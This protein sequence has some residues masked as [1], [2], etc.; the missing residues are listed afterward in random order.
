M[1]L[2]GNPHSC[3]I[4][5]VNLVSCLLP[6]HTC[7]P[8]Y[9][10]LCLHFSRPLLSYEPCI[11]LHYITI[12]LIFKK[13]RK[14]DPGN[15]QA[16]SLISV[17]GKIMEQILLEDMLRCMEDRELIQDSQHGFTKG[18]TCL[19]NLVTFYGVTTSMDK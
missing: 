18:K 5:I 1:D 3:G 4:S 16:V 17:P 13:G 14:D 19:T 15:F 12:L 10:I 2:G 8:L 9:N 11:S 7:S 6:S